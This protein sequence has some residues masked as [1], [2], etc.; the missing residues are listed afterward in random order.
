MRACARRSLAQGIPVNVYVHP[1]EV[2]PG[3]PRLPLPL[4]RRFMTYVNVGRG[5]RKVLALLRAFPAA[6]FRRLGD[7]YREI[8]AGSLPAVYV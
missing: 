2:D 5:E 6:R 4:K 8:A 3:Q 7:V 1:R